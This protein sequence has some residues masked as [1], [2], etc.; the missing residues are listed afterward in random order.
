MSVGKCFLRVR[1]RPIADIAGIPVVP[2]T[3]G[4]NCKAMAERIHWLGGTC[5]RLYSAFAC[6][7]RPQASGYLDFGIGSNSCGAIT[8]GGNSMKISS[9][10]RLTVFSLALSVNGTALHAAPGEAAIA[11]TTQPSP[12]SSD[13][14]AMRAVVESFCDSWT[15]HD[16]GA[17]HAL[18]TGD[19]EWV[20]VVGNDWHGLAEVQKG[21]ANYHHFLAAG[22]T[23]SVESVAVHPI[24]PDVA[25]AVT[26][27]HFGG[28]GPD[29][30]TEDTRTR[31]SM[32]MVKRDGE[33]KITH[34]Q[35]T[36]INPAT[37]GPADPLNFDESTGLPAT[38]G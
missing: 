33:W 7:E 6:S 1:F 10:I 24:A 2:R 3:V 22:S 13:E 11:A 17:M 34:Q 28:V 25:V 8:A 27:F 29:G 23:C 16:M 15:R 21:H 9:A 18:V 4:H 12:V 38:G 20:N 30:T 37:Q 26:S 19:V 5:A 31:S 14:A 36:I 35:N 32:V